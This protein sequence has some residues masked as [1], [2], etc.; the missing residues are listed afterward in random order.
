MSAVKSETRQAAG[1]VEETLE[2]DRPA[3]IFD[4]GGVLLDWNPRRVFLKYFNE[5][6]DAV[7]KFLA[8]ADFFAWNYEQDRGRPYAEGVA[9]ASARFP[10]FAEYFK[11]YDV[12]WDESLSGQIQSSVDTLKPL[13]D[14]GY[15]LYALT[16]WSHE[17]YTFVDR[18]FAFLELFESILVS[19]Q[20][21]IAKPDPRIFQLMLEQIGRPA[22]ECVFID[23]SAAN[24]NTARALGFK[25]I[26][27]ESSDQMIAEMRQLGIKL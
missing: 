12:F 26:Q 21:Q 17:K 6:A 10:E 27:Y 8:D 14:G 7:E 1:L 22:G 13:K 24:I 16:N 18:R 2:S 20:V 3:I 25:T 11:A 19:G 4:F 9:E 15:K 5:D 23:D